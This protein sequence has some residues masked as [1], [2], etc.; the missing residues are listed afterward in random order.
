MR[1]N[2][3]M[4]VYAIFRLRPK[5]AAKKFKIS[6]VIGRLRHVTLELKAKN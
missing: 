2:T 4:Q 3:S 5:R 1:D 6:T